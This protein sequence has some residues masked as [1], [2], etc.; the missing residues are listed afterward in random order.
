MAPLSGSRV[1]VAVSAQQCGILPISQQST[2]VLGS[3]AYH[4]YE[5]VA[6]RDEEKPRLQADLGQANYFMLRNHG[7]LTGADFAT[8]PNKAIRNTYS[9]AK[10]NLSAQPNFSSCNSTCRSTPTIASKSDPN[11]CF[12]LSDRFQVS[13][14][15][16]SILALKT[17]HNA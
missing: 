11:A 7:L 13:V 5:G 4:A 6:F 16:L 8:K 15:G 9:R 3:L 10:E 17:S 14:T 2:F 1:G 12:D